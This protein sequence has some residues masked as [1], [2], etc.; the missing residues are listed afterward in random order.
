MITWYVLSTGHRCD[1]GNL[2]LVPGTRSCCLRAALP[3]K[4]AAR[5]IPQ[6]QQTFPLTFVRD[7]RAGGE[8]N[9]RKEEEGELGCYDMFDTY[10]MHAIPVWATSID[11]QVH[12]IHTSTHRVEDQD[13]VGSR[14]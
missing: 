8:P 13:Y 9:G 2:L 3:I 11:Y 10:L 1:S 7:S 12:R 6:R 5:Y 4:T 14:L